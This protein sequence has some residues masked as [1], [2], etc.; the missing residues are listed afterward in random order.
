MLFG[1]QYGL[2]GKKLVFMG[3]ELAQVKEWNHDA[4][5]SWDLLADPRHEGVRTWLAHLNAV[6]RRE[7]ALH[8]RDVDPE[9]FEWV[10]AGDTAASVISF[11]R[12]PARDADPVDG[13]GNRRRP[14]LVV[15]NFTPVPRQ[16]YA[17]GVP[18]GGRWVELANSD[19]EV[20]GGSGWGNLGGVDAV[21][22]PMHG[23]PFHL[24]LVLP[25]LAV[26]LLAPDDV[27]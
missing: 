21:E 11:L 5:L 3:A 8:E 19:A 7:P 4:E 27:V 24:P 17:I 15:A 16:A 26:V 23:R 22:A 25:P 2:P 20:H 14:V 9:G 6:H 12:W 13:A 18:S 10:A 1:Y